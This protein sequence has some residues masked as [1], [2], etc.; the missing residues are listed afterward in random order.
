MTQ[1]PDRQQMSTGINMTRANLP[2]GHSGA[3]KAPT[4]VVIFGPRELHPAILASI[5]SQL[6]FESS[7][8]VKRVIRRSAYTG[9]RAGVA[10]GI[11]NAERWRKDYHLTGW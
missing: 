11:G 6:T 7:G 10:M 8:T 9:A 4:S 5:I 2:Y 3:R 1:S